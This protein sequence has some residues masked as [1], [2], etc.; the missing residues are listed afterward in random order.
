MSPFFVFKK[1]N[2]KLVRIEAFYWNWGFYDE[3]CIENIVDFAAYVN[4]QEFHEEQELDYS[5]L[6]N[7]I[8]EYKYGKDDE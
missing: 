4:E 5:W 7:L 2:G 3:E 1:D 6:T 8:H